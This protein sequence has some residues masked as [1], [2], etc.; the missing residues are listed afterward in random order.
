MEA[1]F[2][3]TPDIDSAYVQCQEQLVAA[4]SVDLD[5][6]AYETSDCNRAH[7]HKFLVWEAGFR[8]PAIPARPYA[9]VLRKLDYSQIG[10]QGGSQTLSYPQLAKTGGLHLNMLPRIMVL[11]DGIDPTSRLYQR[12]ALPLS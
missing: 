7:R 6:V 9:G 4:S 12:R 8:L 2:S 11:P 10:P 3:R 5:S 1:R